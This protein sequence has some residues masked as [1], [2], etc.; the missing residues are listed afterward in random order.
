MKKIVSLLLAAVLSMGM[1]AGCGEQMSEEEKTYKESCTPYTY[2]ELMEL[3]EGQRATFSGK[4]IEHRV[5]TAGEPFA[6]VEYEG[7]EAKVWADGLDQYDDGDNITIWG[8][9]HVSVAK[10]GGDMT[11]IFTFKAKYI[12]KAK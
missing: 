12:S 4:I 8:E 11:K 5:D 1:L 7:K 2:E 10:G 6:F 3:P 9:K